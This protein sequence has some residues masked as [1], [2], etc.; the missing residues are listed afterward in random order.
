MKTFRQGDVLIHEID[1]LP[2]NLSK[3]TSKTLVYG[4]VTGHS[5]RLQKGQVWK[6][7]KDNLFL[8]VT[9]PTMIVHEEH[10]P[11]KLDKGFYAII[12]QREYTSADMTRLVID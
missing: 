3:V 4:E 11:I 2:D 1:R 7:D 9:T 5:H 10:K 8:D 6:D 12:R